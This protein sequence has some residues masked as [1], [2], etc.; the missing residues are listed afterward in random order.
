MNHSH[1]PHIDLYTKPCTISQA[2]ELYTQGRLIFPEAP[3]FSMKT[4]RQKQAG[5]MRAVFMGLEL[6][7]VYVSERQDGSLL[8]LDTGD[9]LKALLLFLDGQFD[10]GDIEGYPGLEG[11]TIG[12]LGAREPGLAAVLGDHRLE[13]RVIDYST[14][15]YLHMEAGL[16]MEKWNFSREQGIRNGLYGRQAAERL[17]GASAR[18]YRRKPEF[19]SGKDLNRQY[20]ILRILMTALVLRGDIQLEQEEDLGLQQLLDHT[21]V[22]LDRAREEQ[23]E[24]AEGFLV[25]ATERLVEWQDSEQLLLKDKGKEPQVRLLSVLYNLA[26]LEKGYRKRL[27]DPVMENVAFLEA[28]RESPVSYRAIK[29]DYDRFVK[30]IV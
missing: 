1:P 27:L 6:P 13:L 28:F 5:M 3:L 9:W 18:M 17:S 10:S 25:S 7:A 12:E 11:C 20:T 26:W 24:R 2:Y 30:E 29:D 23:Y 14:P 15:R 16:L 19:L 8:V 21:M 4:R 22:W